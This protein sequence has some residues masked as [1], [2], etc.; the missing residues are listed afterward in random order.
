MK[1]YLCLLLVASCRYSVIA[2]DIV[3]D[4]CNKLVDN[5][6]TYNF[7]VAFLQT[8]PK[9]K[10]SNIQELDLISIELSIA[11]LTSYIPFIQDQIKNHGGDA[12]TRSSLTACLVTYDDGISSLYQAKKLFE[13][14]DYSGTLELLRN[15]AG[16]PDQCEGKFSKQNSPL[17]EM[18]N[19]CRSV[20]IIPLHIT[21]L[22]K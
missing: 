11:N 17:T 1:L 18:N 12:E 6:L 2:A 22:L 16:T 4:T 8:D 3:A 13:S 10:T 9:S 7:C 5:H 21:S 15:A 14:W 19:I 20:L